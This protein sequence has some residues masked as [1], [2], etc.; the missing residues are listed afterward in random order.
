MSDWEK[1]IFTALMTLGATL[2]GF[3]ASQF[4]QKFLLDP[5]QEQAKIIGEVCFRLTYYASWYA[6]PGPRATKEQNDQLIEASNALRE[7]ASRLEAIT[8]TIWWYTFFEIMKLVP[9]RSGVEKAVGNLIGIS[10]STFTE[11]I[12]VKREIKSDTN[13][14]RKLLRCER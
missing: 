6:N 5:I 12:E 8:H 13:E 9:K 3:S 11:N 14:I 10:N 1:I 7:C 4:I 2:I